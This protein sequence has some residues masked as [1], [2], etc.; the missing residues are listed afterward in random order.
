MQ[1]RHFIWYE[2]VTNDMDGAASFYGK[3]LGWRAAPVPMDGKQYH[4]LTLPEDGQVAGMMPLTAEAAA[5]G[6]RAGWYGYVS[7]ADVDASAVQARGLGG[8]VH[9]P[10]TEIPGIGRFAVLGDP[11]GAVICLFAGDGE[12]PPASLRATGRVGWHELMADDWQAA[13]GFYAAMFG[14]RK[15]RAVDTG[16]MGTYQLFAAGEE[17]MGGMFDKPAA[18]PMPAWLYYFNVDDIDA[19]AD[20]VTGG[21]GQIVNGPMEVPGGMWIVQC[22]DPQGVMFALV[23][24]RF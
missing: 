1:P 4:L 18:V 10:P 9:L 24:R 13:F 20:R 17:A 12:M 16:S 6:A 14:W 21:G 3:L 8:K 22:V 11:Q 2:L 15:D 23:G 5:M 7:V 19:A